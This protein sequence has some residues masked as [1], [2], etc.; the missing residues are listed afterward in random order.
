MT[1][2]ASPPTEADLARELAAIEPPAPPPP[3]PVADDRRS[4][5]RERKR[6]RQHAASEAERAER[7]ARSV[8]TG[9][10]AELAIVK[11][12]E[13]GAAV[14]PSEAEEVACAFCTAVVT[15]PTELRD[16]VRAAANLTVQ[17]KR[18]ERVVV[19]LLDQPSA[20]ETTTWIAVSSLFIAAAWPVTAWVYVHL[21]HAHRLTFER[22]ALIAALPFLLALDGFFLSR[23]R[24]VDRVALRSLALTFAARAPAREGD[25][26]CCRACLGPLP[27][28]TTT[29]IACVYCGSANVTRVD[30]RGRARKS[31]LSVASLEHA[32]VAHDRER[33][34]WRLAMILGAASF[35]ATGAVLR[36][37]LR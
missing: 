6:Q 3:P 12:A 14:A 33:L 15:I 25:P 17:A 5:K 9:P 21:G 26:P 24:L 34:W 2:R 4:R 16:R 30:L 32:L 35:V 37:V 29:V 22:G 10:A 8:V 7:A 11:C 13:C 18:A 31:E 23:L 20:R 36:H 19:K 27:A 1:E 28:L